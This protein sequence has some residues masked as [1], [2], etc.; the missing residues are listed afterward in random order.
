MAVGLEE[1][2]TTNEGFRKIPVILV[3]F[4]RA[5]NDTVF[6][7]INQDAREYT[8][9]CFQVIKRYSCVIRGEKK[10]G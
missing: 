3:G 9:R 10:L 6:E 7:R 5:K 8:Y 2:S 1:I 4:Q